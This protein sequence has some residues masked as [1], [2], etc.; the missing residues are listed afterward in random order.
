MTDWADYY[1]DKS[2][3]DMMAETELS[4]WLSSIYRRTDELMAGMS[5]PHYRKLSKQEML[6]AFNLG[7]DDIQLMDQ[8]ATRFQLIATDIL[9][10][11]DRQLRVVNNG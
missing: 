3:D 4:Q 5:N 2:D 9:S 7:Y 1:Q 11:R 6:A 8:L 10:R